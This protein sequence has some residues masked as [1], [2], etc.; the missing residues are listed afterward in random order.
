MSLSIAEPARGHEFDSGGA[1]E[2]QSAG[3][4]EYEIEMFDQGNQGSSGDE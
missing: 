1:G 2:P 4:L 3:R